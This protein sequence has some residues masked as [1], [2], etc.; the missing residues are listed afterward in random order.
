[1][2]TP[3][4]TTAI[5]A[6]LTAAG[7]RAEV[8]PTGGNC[9]AIGV[10]APDAPSRGLY[11]DEES[12]LVTDGNAGLPEDSDPGV[13]AGRYDD[14]DVIAERWIPEATPAD[15]VGAVLELLAEVTP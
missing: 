14:G 5:L 7:L 12:V 10:T 6:A 1:M 2:T 9:W 4:R 15:V 3:A 8:I 13:W 11:P